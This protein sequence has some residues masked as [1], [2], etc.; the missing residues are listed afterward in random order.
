MSSSKHNDED[1][2][3]IVSE[4]FNEYSAI[5]CSLGQ[6]YL[7]HFNQLDTTKILLSKK[8][9]VTQAEKRGLPTEESSL[10]FIIEEEMWDEDKEKEI[11]KK[12]NFIENLRQGLTKLKLPSQREN[13]K[14]LIRAEQQKLKEV[15]E[16]RNALI[17]LTAE[18]Y[19][20]K[21][22][23]RDFFE[24]IA[25]FDK[26][27]T[28]PVLENVTYDNKELELEISQIQKDFFE[29]FSDGNISKAV[30]SNFYNPYLPFSDDPTQIFGKCLSQMT[31]FQLK[32]CTYGKTFLSIFK[33]SPKEIPP[34]VAKDPELLMEFAESLKHDR[35]KNT[36]STEGD[37]GSVV[38]GGKESD[39]EAIK[40]EDETATH[41]NKAIEDQ[42][43]KK[44]GGLNM[45]DL[46]KI[47]GV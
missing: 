30:L 1:L 7:K 16:E 11:Q 27:L 17:G 37:G 10:N 31:T 15:S 18:K 29:K 26:E 45:R 40:T 9:Y 8:N 21:R 36:K 14:E 2:I 25:Y 33:N 47:H 39:L 3:Y 22:A 46:M 38:F 4:I 35:K 43:N 19:A 28:K 41:L 24:S 42:N 23:N 20:E 32:M 12:T 44:Q 6:I 5:E 13:H 34:N